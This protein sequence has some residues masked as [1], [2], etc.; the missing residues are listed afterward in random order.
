MWL[1]NYSSPLVYVKVLFVIQVCKFT[2]PH[3]LYNV[4]EPNK[5]S[6]DKDT[7]FDTQSFSDSLTI[8]IT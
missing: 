3:L 2:L 4:A 5:F 7:A 1:G 6:S 8:Y